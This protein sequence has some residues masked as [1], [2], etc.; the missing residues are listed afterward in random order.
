[1]SW[2]P[3]VPGRACATK[4][5]T[6]KEHDVQSGAGAEESGHGGKAAIRQTRPVTLS[7]AYR[8]THSPPG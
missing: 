6:D 7:D 4:Q 3:E 8:R 2:V 1:M 5:T